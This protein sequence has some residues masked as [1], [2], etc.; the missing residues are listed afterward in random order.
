MD[1]RE[2]PR[3]GGHLKSIQILRASRRDM[4]PQQD[5][6][7]GVIICPAYRWGQR[8]RVNSFTTHNVEIVAQRNRR[9]SAL[10]QWRSI[11]HAARCPIVDKRKRCPTMQMACERHE[12]PASADLC[13]SE[14]I[15]HSR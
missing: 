9:A 2:R 7:S 3:Q 4:T 1:T 14:R 13:T 15:I 10:K 12:V 11:S 6:L 5:S 8:L